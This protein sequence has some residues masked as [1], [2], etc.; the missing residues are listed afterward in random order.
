MSNAKTVGELLD[1]LGAASVEEHAAV[2]KDYPQA[3][4]LND[5]FEMGAAYARERF[6]PVL[7]AL[8]GAQGRVV[9]TA[10]D[11]E[12]AAKALADA[13]SMRECGKPRLPGAYVFFLDDARAAITAAGGVVCE[14]FWEV[15]CLATI[16][17]RDE[18]KPKT[19]L[20]MYGL[21]PGDKLYIVR[22][23]EE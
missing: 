18:D 9:Y 4:A 5:G 19:K 13:E 22:A 12:R 16:K 10:E 20:V 1:R 11:V 3:S 23:K 21:L 7:G 6:K 15:D 17:I 8:I 2:V 14:E